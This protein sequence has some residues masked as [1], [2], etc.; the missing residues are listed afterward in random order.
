MLLGI[1]G[2]EEGGVG[3]ER[4]W[5]AGGRLNSLLR[6]FGLSMNPRSASYRSKHA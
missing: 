1:S 3:G 5:E 6:V 4:G 2:W